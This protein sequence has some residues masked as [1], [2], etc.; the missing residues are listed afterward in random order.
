MNL[1]LIYIILENVTVF[2]LSLSV[3]QSKQEDLQIER[4]RNSFYINNFIC[5]CSD[6]SFP[7]D[8]L[9]QRHKD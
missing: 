8:A 5:I 4:N 1:N 3:S 6:V 2:S 9:T 7:S